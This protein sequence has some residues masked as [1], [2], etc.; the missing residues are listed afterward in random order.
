MKKPPNTQQWLNSANWG[1]PDNTYKTLNINTRVS[2]EK[3]PAGA[4]GWIGSATHTTVLPDME[5]YNLFTLAGFDA[6]LFYLKK[7]VNYKTAQNVVYKKY[8]QNKTAT[9]L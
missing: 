4:D 6:K 1:N 7:C 3:S 9:H 5:K 2:Y 8:E